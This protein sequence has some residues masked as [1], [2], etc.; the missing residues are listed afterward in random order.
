MGATTWVQETTNR[1]EKQQQ[2]RRRPREQQQPGE[3]RGIL[4]RVTQELAAVEATKEMQQ[5]GIPL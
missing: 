1:R 4:H 3:K 5:K 2:P